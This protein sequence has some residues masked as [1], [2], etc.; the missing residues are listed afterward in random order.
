MTFFP[1][2]MDSSRVPVLPVDG[3]TTLASVADCGVFVPEAKAAGEMTSVDI[4]RLSAGNI[5]FV[6]RSVSIPDLFPVVLVADFSGAFFSGV[7]TGLVFFPTAAM[8]GPEVM[9]GNA[10]VTPVAGV[11]CAAEK[12]PAKTIFS[13]S[14]L[15]APGCSI[16][17]SDKKTGNGVPVSFARVGRLAIRSVAV[18]SLDAAGDP[19]GWP[20]VAFALMLLPA[21]PGMQPASLAVVS[22]AGCDLPACP[23]VKA[24]VAFPLC[25]RLS[26]CSFDF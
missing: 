10:L 4:F 22:P 5:S 12:S 23:L 9:V 13:A 14:T 15:P 19:S 16:S 21:F 18:V 24:A 11:G 2:S 25:G 8:A 26:G 20:D 1:A 7:V 3:G 17:G 6:G